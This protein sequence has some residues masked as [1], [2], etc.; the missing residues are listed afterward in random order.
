LGRGANFI[1]PFARGLHVNI[2]APYDVRVKRAMKYEGFNEEKAKEVIARVQKEREEFVKTYFK[3]DAKKSNAY[4]LTLNTTHYSIDEAV[5][6]IML[7]FRRKFP[8]FTRL[9]ASL[10]GK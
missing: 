9:K 8:A 7:A 10:L 4:D 5:D 1:T 2:V 6:V 3:K